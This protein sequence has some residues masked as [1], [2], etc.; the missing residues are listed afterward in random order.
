MELNDIVNLYIKKGWKAGWDMSSLS[1]GKFTIY[2]SKTQPNIRVCYT[3]MDLPYGNI[4]SL[5][6]MTHSW[7]EEKVVK[8][9]DVCNYIKY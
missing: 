1:K 6:L 3:D 5:S 8:F 9:I 7:S 2:F 4:A